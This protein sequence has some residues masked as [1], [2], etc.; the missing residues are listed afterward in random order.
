MQNHR[1]L[2][3]FMYLITILD[4]TSLTNRWVDGF[5]HITVIVNGDIFWKSSSSLVICHKSL[6]STMICEKNFKIF[7]S[8]TI[9]VFNL[10]FLLIEKLFEYFYL[11]SNFQFFF[12]FLN[13]YLI[14]YSVCIFIF[15]L[16][17]KYLFLKMHNITFFTSSTDHFFLPDE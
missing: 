6:L 16:I 4:L 1:I 13:F 7:F 3:F 12:V 10:F 17:I 11:F 15:I 9:S 8:V 14:F 2:K 5:Q